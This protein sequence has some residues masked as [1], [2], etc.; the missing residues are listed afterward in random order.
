MEHIWGQEG[1]FGWWSLLVLFYLYC[2]LIASIIRNDKWGQFILYKINIVQ[3]IGIKYFKLTF[4]S[5]DIL[6]LIKFNFFGNLQIYLL[7]WDNF[8]EPNVTKSRQG[9]SSSFRML[10]KMS[11]RVLIVNCWRQQVTL[12]CQCRQY[13]V[14]CREKHFV[15]ALFAHFVLTAKNATPLHH[16]INLPLLKQRK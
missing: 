11:T 8:S 3:K 14:F 2:Q 9:T 16:G 15:I 6:L 10:I 13:I 5:F 4:I 1:T 12:Q 7:S